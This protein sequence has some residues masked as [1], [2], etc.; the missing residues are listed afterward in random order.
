MPIVA[1]DLLYGATM[2]ARKIKYVVMLLLFSSFICG[3]N[4]YQA[5]DSSINTTT[6]NDLISEGDGRLAEADYSTALNRF[7]RALEKTNDDR[8]RRGR[9]S[10]YAGL[11]GFNM[12]SVLNRFQNDLAAPNT[13]AAVFQATKEITSLENLNKAIDDM[14]LISEPSNDD[15]LFRALMTSISAA[16]TILEK[17]DTNLNSKLDYPD[18]I[19]FTTNDNKTKT[20]EHLY[21]NFSSASSQYSIEK[22]YIELT[23]ALDGRGTTWATMSPFNSVTKSGKYTL[24]NYNIIVAV[25][26]LGLKI[27]EAN[28]KFNNSASE[29][30]TAIMN[31]DGVD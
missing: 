10:A 19:N 5:L 11:A 12:F 23:I 31:L 17:Y 26:D 6:A 4:M 16:K 30:K 21:A 9:A 25:G 29:F 15:L 22:A 7:D 20:W 3:C 18:Q 1:T 14:M 13:S 2:K 24:A 27:K 28:I 8:A